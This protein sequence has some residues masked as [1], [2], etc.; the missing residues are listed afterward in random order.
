MFEKKKFNQPE[1]STQPSSWEKLAALKKSMQVT[2]AG[3]AVGGV[4]EA[5][6]ALQKFETI[7]P[8]Q[9]TLTVGD[10]E[11]YRNAVAWGPVEFSS[12]RLV[13]D[14]TENGKTVRYPDKQG[15]Q[16]RDW[17]FQLGQGEPMVTEGINKPLEELSNLD[18]IELDVD[19]YTGIDK[20]NPKIIVTKAEY[21]NVIRSIGEQKQEGVL[22]V[23]NQIYNKTVASTYNLL[24]GAW[25]FNRYF[26]DPKHAL[27]QGDTLDALAI[28]NL[29][30]LSPWLVPS[31]GISGGKFTYAMPGAGVCGF[32]SALGQEIYSKSASSE[33]LRD[34]AGEWM[35]LTDVA[36]A[37]KIDPTQPLFSTPQ[38][39]AHSSVNGSDLTYFGDDT[40]KG[41]DFT[42]F[43]SSA[44]GQG[45]NLTAKILQGDGIYFRVVPEFVPF[46]TATIKKRLSENNGNYAKT[47]G[48]GHIVFRIEMLTHPTTPQDI[49]VVASE[50]QQLV[51][52]FPKL[53]E[54]YKKTGPFLK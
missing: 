31:K 14:K 35:A 43:S 15:M 22:S 46:D 2:L 47:A 41:V 4:I 13:Y 42:I 32:W 6:S 30:E 29:N 16:L 23:R 54:Q 9:D 7:A 17:S 39:R 50:I 48:V 33:R 10:L 3:L 26:R 21:E 45:V 53:R 51:K 1:T 38:G 52:Q 24:V 18:T 20:T 11:K 37:E 12:A 34:R 19:N 36:G 25:Q 44:P 28:M 49:Q 27:K 5:Q 8:Y 40:P